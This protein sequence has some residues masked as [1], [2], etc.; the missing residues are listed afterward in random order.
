MVSGNRLII[1]QYKV[2]VDFVT[3]PVIWIPG[4][5]FDYCET[6]YFYFFI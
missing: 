2:V 5:V 6:H 3:A 1:V 4:N